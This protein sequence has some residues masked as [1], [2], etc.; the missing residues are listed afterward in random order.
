[1]TPIEAAGAGKALQTRENSVKW[2]IEKHLT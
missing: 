1:M 2:L